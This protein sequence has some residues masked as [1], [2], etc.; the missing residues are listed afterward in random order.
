MLYLDASSLV[1]RYY[2][3]AGSDAVNARFALGER[4]FT[5]VLSYAEV[6][7]ALGRKYH[8]RTLSR[9]GFKRARNRF[10]QD[11][12][13]DFSVLEMDTNTMAA[14]PALVERNAIRGADAVHLSAALWLRDMVRLFPEFAPGERTVE[15]GTA[16]KQLERYARHWSEQFAPDSGLAVVHF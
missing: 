3:E 13:L 10:L 1:K 4:I 9:T 11:F 6:Q 16:D 15:F 5:S 2:Q 8:Q 14:V 7:A 12:V